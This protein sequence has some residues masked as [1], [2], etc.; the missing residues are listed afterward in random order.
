MSTARNPLGAQFATIV[1]QTVTGPPAFAFVPAISLSAFWFGGEIAL[2]IVSCAMPILYLLAGGFRRTPT[3]GAEGSDGHAGLASRAHFGWQV[4]RVHARA[5]QTGRQSAL[6]VLIIEDLEK[7]TATHGTAAALRVQEQ[8][9]DRLLSAMRADDTVGALSDSQ[10]SVCLSLVRHLDLES[11]IQMAGR[12][13]SVAELPVSVDGVS[14]YVSVSVGFCQLARAPGDDGAAWLAAAATAAAEAVSR[15]PSAMRGY[16]DS[17]RRQT[18]IRSALRD[19]VEQALENGEIKPWFQPQISTDTGLISGFEALA[20]WSHPT[21]GLILPAEFLPVVEAAGKLERL[22]EVV[23]YHA[24][25]AVKAWDS[26]GVSVP[27]V[28]V[29]FDGAELKNPQII[30]KIEWELD[31]F[32]LSPERLS[33]EI[34][35]TVV[36]SEPDDMITRNV[37]ALGELGCRIDLDDFGTGHASIASIRRFSVSRIKIDRSFV[38]KADRDPE[39]QRMISAILTMAERL[40]IETL[41]EGVE[42]VGEHVLLAQL[43]CHHVQGYGIARPM[44]FEETLDWIVSHNAKLE[45]TPRIMEG[46]SR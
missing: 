18:Q 29:N 14:V 37:I 24:F 20:R 25:A 8:I 21:R 43:G 3:E 9:G 44:P 1:L 26:A 31:R 45:D 41:A 38:M 11:C 17:M 27:Q 33:V 16:S 32:D 34:L 22:A 40:N 28:G 23:M 35:E 12:M 46:R 42:S 15:G 5:S 30:N 4:D 6:F 19:D 10:L 39:Q 7:I 36:T 13:Q 2:I